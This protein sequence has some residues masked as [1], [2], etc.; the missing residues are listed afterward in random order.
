VGSR[1]LDIVGSVSRND[2]GSSGRTRTRLWRFRGAVGRYI[3]PM[4]RPLAS[5]LPTFG[6]LT[7]RGRKSGRTYRT[8]INVFRQGET[9]FFFL[10]YGSDVEWVK[11]VLAGSCTVE[12]RGRVISSSNPN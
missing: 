7:L 1:A 9:Y 8:P 6:I 12:T 3:N 2:T 5:K 10:T 4:T 11:S